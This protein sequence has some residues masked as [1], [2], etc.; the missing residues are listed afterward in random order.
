MLS[1]EFL[2]ECLLFDDYIIKEVVEWVKYVI[3]CVI[4][5]WRVFFF[6]FFVLFFFYSKVCMYFWVG[7]S[8]G[9][10]RVVIV[11][12]Y[13]I[14][15]FICI[16]SIIGVSIELWMGGGD[17]EFWGVD[18]EIGKRCWWDFGWRWVGGVVFR[19]FWG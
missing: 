12:S 7:L 11:E 1:K 13:I 18:N 9:K 14:I 5:V 8:L 17:D 4:F 6:V 3:I 16:I 15:S 2:N 19:W 10:G